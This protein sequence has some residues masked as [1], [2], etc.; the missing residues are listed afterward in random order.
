MRLMRLRIEMFGLFSKQIKFYAHV[1]ACSRIVWLSH[2]TVP[3]VFLDGLIIQAGD[4]KAKLKRKYEKMTSLSQ[5]SQ[6]KGHTVNGHLFADTKYKT[7]GKTQS[8][9]K[10]PGKSPIDHT[11]GFLSF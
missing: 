9:L 10:V 8:K 6:R 7:F 2:A 5:I 11:K 1:T 3:L 4:S